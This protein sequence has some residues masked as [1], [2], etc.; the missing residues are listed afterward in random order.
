VLN[1]DPLGDVT[2]RQ[3][4]TPKIPTDDTLA[5]GNQYASGGTVNYG[6]LIVD[7]EEV[8][9]PGAS[10]SLAN[11]FS[12]NKSSS[13]FT[14]L[15]NDRSQLIPGSGVPYFQLEHSGG[16]T[17]NSHYLKPAPS[18]FRCPGYADL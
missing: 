5:L 16:N 18:R 10:L 9:S 7:S 3:A 12:G 11:G 14:F 17:P 6:K 4:G 2:L 13:T 8:T 15:G 1:I